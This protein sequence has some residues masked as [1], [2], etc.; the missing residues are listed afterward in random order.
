MQR[1]GFG[2]ETNAGAGQTVPTARPL[3]ANGQV[4]PA[5]AVHVQ[6]GAHE[7]AFE[8][9]VQQGEE[10][11]TIADRLLVGGATVPISVGLAGESVVVVGE[12]RIARLG[13]DSFTLR[14][15]LTAPEA[16]AL[17]QRLV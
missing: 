4:F 16:R 1:P 6:F 3:C 15:R 10:L 12:L 5:G 9:D 2:G 13:D 17:A 14:I 7:D 8:F 11:F